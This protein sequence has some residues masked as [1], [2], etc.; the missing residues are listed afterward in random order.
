MK[1]FTYLFILVLFSCSQQRDT[2]TSFSGTLAVAKA[3]TVPSDTSQIALFERPG[4]ISVIPDTAWMSKEQKT[5]SE[6]DWS[7]TLDDAMY[8]QSM[9]LDTLESIGI[10]SYSYTFIDKRYY[11]FKLSDGRDFVVDM[12]KIPGS[13]GVILYNGKDEPSLYSS[14]EVANVMD[15][16]FNR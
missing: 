2:T 12:N 4:S 5:M 16:V 11:K 13:W 6:E 3:E 7:T 1:Y 9:A 15:S 10:E 14:M 8:Y